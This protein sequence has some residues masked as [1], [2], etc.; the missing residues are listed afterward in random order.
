MLQVT[1]SQL[2]NRL[3]AYLKRAQG[4]ESILVL[5]RDKPIAMLEKVDATAYPD[6]RLARLEQAGAVRTSRTADPVSALAG[7]RRP[8]ALVSVVDALLDERRLG[9]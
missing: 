9:R 8:R 6:S 7:T 5:D 1:I 2:K 4:G 3:S